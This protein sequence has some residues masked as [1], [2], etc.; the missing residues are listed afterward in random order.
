MSYGL[1]KSRIL[2]HRQCPKRL[3]LQVYRPELADE[4]M[5]QSVM[6]TGGSVGAIARQ[7]H[8][9]GV[10]IDVQ[11]LRQALHQTRLALKSRPR[12]PLFEGTFEHDGVLVRADL[13]IPQARGWRMV[14]VK[15]STSVKDDQVE[16]AA[17]QSWVLRQAGEPLRA[18]AIAHVDRDF[19]GPG[20]GN[21]EGLLTAENVGKTIAERLPEVPQWIQAARSTLDAGREPEIEP[22]P[23]CN[24][25]FACPFQSHCIPE[26]QGY[27]VDI[28]SYGAKVAAQLRAEG[29]ADLRDV[30]SGRLTHHRHLRIWEASC[31]GK[32]YVAPEL[33]DIL[34]R[35]PYPRYYID[36]ETINPAIPLWA[37]T[38]PYQQ[39]PFQW[40]C[41]A[42]HADA[43]LRHTAFLADGPNDP[44]RAFA[45]SLLQVVGTSGPVLVWSQSFE[46]GRLVELADA[47]PNLAPALHKLIGRLVDLLPLA[48]EHYYHPDMMGSWSI[49]AVLPTIAP[50]LA[51]DNLEVADG[52]MAQEAFTNILLQ[53]M[54]P[55]QRESTRQAL[56]VYCERD[57]LAMVKIVQ[58]VCD[59]AP[60]K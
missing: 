27:P 55:E 53:Q 24:D 54:P 13:L 10:L 26:P 18:E 50:E 44:R 25:P 14:E 12:R 32:A 9:D 56:L 52:G 2:S 3:W 38:R 20:D 60:K 40:S 22:G 28:L 15:S 39:I 7:L 36:F 1:S 59:K 5:S 31:T 47:F 58:F 42:Q 46:Q 8:P 43:S 21:Y 16:D 49:K 4:T 6:A 45:T 51:Y 33:R 41:H 30:P 19:V 37:G 35:L 11:D 48:R 57:T 29:Y 34:Q 17:I 23:Q